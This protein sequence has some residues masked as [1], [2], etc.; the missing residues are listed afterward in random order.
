MTYAREAFDPLSQ[1]I[2][3]AFA[4]S[5]CYFINRVTKETRETTTFI[6]HFGPFIG[7]L[8]LTVAHFDR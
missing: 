7:Y 5:S 2:C 1:F 4:R 8:R 3:D 6:L